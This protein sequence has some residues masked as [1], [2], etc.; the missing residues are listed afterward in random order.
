VAEIAAV[1]VDSEVEGE[2][3]E[4]DSAV[5]GEEIGVVVAAVVEEAAQ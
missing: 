5:E 1:A 3:T 4:E 2:E